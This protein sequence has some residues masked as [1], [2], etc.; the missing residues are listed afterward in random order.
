MEPVGIG[1]AF[2]TGP[3][4]KGIKDETFRIDYLIRTAKVEKFSLQPIRFKQDGWSL[5]L[6]LCGSGPGWEVYGHLPFKD[7]K[8]AFTLRVGTYGLGFRVL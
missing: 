1:S 3:K 5:G 6:W 2:L 4:P 7:I 8:G